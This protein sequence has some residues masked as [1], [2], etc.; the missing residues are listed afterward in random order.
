MPRISM[1]KGT[2][3]FSVLPISIGTMSLR[4]RTRAKSCPKAC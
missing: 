2:I 4:S 3:R 1:T